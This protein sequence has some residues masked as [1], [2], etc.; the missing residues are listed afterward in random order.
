[1]PTPQSFIVNVCP[2]RTTASTLQLVF[3]DHDLQGFKPVMQKIDGKNSDK[4][5]TL[6]I[7]NFENVLL[8]HCKNNIA[9]LKKEDLNTK[10]SLYNVN[11]FQSITTFCKP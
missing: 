9:V 2:F 8:E 7:C 3:S 6:K 11:P 10:C 1:M 4:S 5:E